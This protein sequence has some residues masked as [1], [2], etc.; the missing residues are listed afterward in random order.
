MAGE[1]LGMIAS[2]DI[3]QVNLPIKHRRE[4]KGAL[5]GR[6]HCQGGPALGPGP[7]AD[8]VREELNVAGPV[9][10]AGGERQT[11]D[12]DAVRL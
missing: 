2:R 11:E 10:Q 6:D 12:R 5:S 1:G 7:D 9:R 4:E 8:R 3:K